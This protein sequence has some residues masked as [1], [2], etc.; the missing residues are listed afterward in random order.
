MG[1]GVGSAPQMDTS[2][3]TFELLKEQPGVRVLNA[4]GQVMREE[5]MADPALVR[6]RVRLWDD[7]VQAGLPDDEFVAFQMISE[8]LRDGEDPLEC[9]GPAELHAMVVGLSG[10]PQHEREL[11]ALFRHWVGALVRDWG[12][13]GPTGPVSPRKRLTWCVRKWLEFSLAR[14]RRVTL[15]HEKHILD[16]FLDRSGRPTAVFPV[17]AGD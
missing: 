11:H 14:E 3:L 12:K 16:V 1:T 5:A 2:G 6:E 10:A 17:L 13:P 15:C 4:Y 9:L 7:T 8:V